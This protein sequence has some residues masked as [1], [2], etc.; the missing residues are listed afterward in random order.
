MVVGVDWLRNVLSGFP[1]DSV[2]GPLLF[3]LDTSEPFVILENKPIGYTDDSNLMV[4]VIPRCFT[5]AESSTRDLGRNSEWCDLSGT[6][7]NASKSK[8]KIVSESRTMDTQS[9]P[10]TIG[11]TVLN[12][13][14]DLDI[15]GVTFDSKMPFE[16]NLRWVSRAAS[17]RSG[18]LLGNP[19]EDYMIDRILGDAFGVL[20]C[21]F[22]SATL[23]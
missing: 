11:G 9:P 2:F 8:T 4:V 6:K 10:L 14:D 13:S 20:S 15:L 21:R 3:L 22:W 19:G 17:H 12:E 5:K 1:Q 16:N 18:I 7:L 23:L